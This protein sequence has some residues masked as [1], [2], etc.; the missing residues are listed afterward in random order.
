MRPLFPWHGGPPKVIVVLPNTTLTGTV[1]TVTPS[2]A[3]PTV[4]TFVLSASADAGLFCD[5]D[6]H[7]LNGNIT[8]VVTASTVFGG[9]LAFAPALEGQLVTVRGALTAT[10]QRVLAKNDDDESDDDNTDRKR[11]A[12]QLVAAEV[13]PAAP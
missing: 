12:V 6:G 9:G 5:N 11:L 10:I 2:T 4:G 1:G 7:P 8:V 3:D 13:N